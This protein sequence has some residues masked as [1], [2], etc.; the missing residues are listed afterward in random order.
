MFPKKTAVFKWISR[1]QDDKEDLQKVKV[2]E[3]IQRRRMKK[4]Y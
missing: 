2:M 1:F 3:D 4:W